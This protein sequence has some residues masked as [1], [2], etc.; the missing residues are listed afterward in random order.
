M[1]IDLAHSERVEE[2]GEPLAGASDRQ[3]LR[4][5]LVLFFERA[6]PAIV[7]GLAPLAVIL[8]L[9]LFDLWRFAGLWGHAAALVVL[10]A[11]AGALFWRRR[12]RPFLPPR[13]DALARLERDGMM[14]HEPLRAL[15][16]APAL[17]ATALWEA[18]LSDARARATRAR[19]LA[20]APT[21]NMIDP[22]GLRYAALGVLAVG[23]IAAGGAAPQRIADAFRPSDPSI[24]RGGFADLWIE[25]PAYTGKAPIY[26]LRAPDAL[27]GRHDQIDAPEGSIV[28][29]QTKA[30]A[31]YRL[32]FRTESETVKSAREGGERSARASLA[33]GESGMLTLSA[34]GRSARWPVGVLEDRAP[35]VDFNAT[36]A[37]DRDGRLA[38]TVTIDD[39][40]GA[41]AASLV[42]R[43]DADQPRP[44][45]AAAFA[46][47][48]T[49]SAEKI[50]LDALKGAPG[51][52]ATT[53]DLSSHPWA[54]LSVIAA[55]K[56]TDAAGQDGETSPVVL[57]LPKRE[58]FNPLA[59]AVIEQRQTLAV[60]PSD[61]R[62]VEWALSGMT[63]GPE[64]FFDRP[65]DY[66]LLRTAMWRVNKRGSENQQSTVEE[67][68]PLALQLENETLELARQRLDA[69][70]QALREALENGV[71]DTDIERLTEG[72][73][74][75]L[76]NYLQALAQS[77]AE[78]D[79]DAPPPDQTVTAADLDAML[80]S[81]RDLAKSGA[82]GAA[83]Q[84]LADLEQLLENL[85]APGGAGEGEAG[86]GGPQGQG[87]QAGAVGDLIGRQ[88]ALADE[89]FRRGEIQGSTGDDLADDESGLAGDLSDLMKS[90]GEGADSGGAEKSLSRALSAMRRAEGALT[91]EDFD[92]A[93]DAMEEAIAEL[94]DGAAAIAKGERAKAQS[95]QGRG[96]QPMRDPLGRPIG[97]AAGQDVDLPEKSDAQRA[98]AF[99][100]ELRRRLSDGERTEDEIKYLERLLERF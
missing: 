95:A 38:I 36:P 80:D 57:I 61:W 55:V 53:V 25:P 85:R 64:Y 51:M 100:E 15:E 40:Y 30:G 83:R 52:H 71:S 58:F 24:A 59:R 92:G 82:A 96:G 5:R 94:R 39:D 68:W 4:A 81:V 20:P 29:I 97:E 50:T 79:P 10:I 60:A 91:G 14:R 41:E 78:L 45:D 77:G 90:L 99:V 33:L 28:R 70:R 43:L 19:L 3:V 69:A 6:A 34:G 72:L 13:G 75:A 9:G 76:Q 32:S 74:A 21:A 42:L 35:R 1:T 12:P 67:F 48:V 73:R 66:L 47:E 23:I 49:G 89:A 54:G 93:R 56:V 98:R 63:L 26:L 7:I 22:H 27:G 2:D 18:H 31:R 65:T 62:R 46:T 87:G 84:A 37:P 86:P 44:L 16:D 11:L 88:R 8:A 17:G